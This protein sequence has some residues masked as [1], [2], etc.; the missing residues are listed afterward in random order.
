[1]RKLRELSTLTISPYGLC[2]V[3]FRVLAGKISSLS[4]TVCV[5]VCVCTCAF[6]CTLICMCRY[7]CF[8]VHVIICSY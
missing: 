4:V 2:L 6:T 3:I 5:C 7:P 8:V 1:M